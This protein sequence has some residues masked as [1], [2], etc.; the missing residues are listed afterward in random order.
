VDLDHPVQSR[1]GLVERLQRGVVHG[2]AVHVR[3][4]LYAERAEPVAGVPGLGDGRLGVVHR[5]AGHEAGE[6]VRV[7]VNQLG[8]GLVADPGQLP[9]GLRRPQV[10][11]RRR[12]DVDHLAV[13]AELVHLPESDVHVDQ[14]R[15]LRHA[16]ADVRRGRRGLQGEEALVVGPRHG[17]TE[18]VDLLH[19]GSQSERVCAGLCD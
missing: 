13:I 14:R 7:A 6:A 2:A 17:V 8:E 16:A 12:A 18:R 10:L 19:H 11:D 3:V 4:D 15:D 9:G 1:H 5:Q